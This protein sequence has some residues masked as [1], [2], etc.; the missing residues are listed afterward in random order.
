MESLSV[1]HYLA[2][3]GA[4]LGLSLVLTPLVRSL[5]RATGQVA[6]PRDTRWHKQ[7]TALL[8]GVAI[9]AATVGVWTAVVLA[10]GWESAGK[11]FLPLILCATGVFLLGLVDDI[12][13]LVPQHKL[14]A[15]IVIVSIFMTFGLRL[16][17]TVSKTAN[18]FLSILWVVGITNAFNLLDNMDGLAAGVA[19]IAGTFLFLTH[20]MNPGGA[21]LSVPFLVLCSVY[22]G[23]LL[24]FLVYNFNPASIFMGDAGSLFLGFVMASLTMVGEGDSVGYSAGKL[25]SVIAIPILILFI[26]ILDTGFVS[27]MRKLFRRPISQG[28][29]DHSSHRLVAIGFS[30][31]KAVLVLYGFAVASGLIAL[32]I[33]ALS[34]GTTLVLILFYLL[35]VGFFWIYLARVKVY[36]GRSVLSEEGTGTVT[37][38]LIQFTYRRRLFE[39]VL[40]LILITAAYYTAYLL[41]FEGPVYYLIGENFRFFLNSLPIVV[42]CQIFCFYVLGIYRGIWEATG[43]S[44]LIDYIKAITLGTV[45]A[46]LILLFVYRF[47]S[48]SRAVFVIHW[49]LLL[50]LISLSR[51]SFRLVDE[52]VKK[53]KQKGKRVLIYGAGAGGRMAA[54]EIENNPSLGL[55]IV[56]FL[57]DN[58]QKFKK[59]IMGYPVLGGRE[60]LEK[61]VR[62]RDVQGILVAFKAR[63]EEVR[64]ELQALF[65]KRDLEVEVRQM[66]MVLE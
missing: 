22:L 17:W 7:E 35:F 58:P 32:A 16:D 31:R 48:F 53:G 38:I 52:G 14:A 15:Q 2:F 62:K 57:D 21:A 34:I 27:F 51:L 8:G 55:V 10:L 40:D 64:R 24:G 6:V 20:Y 47:E 3:F 4:S 56:G 29:R 43:L 13:S 26:P 39:V 50:L 59:K 65:Q 9:F 61:V 12:V 28:G 60:E 49:I 23:A 1:T 30:E 11:P 41:R 54:K 66:K 19:L 46:M 25:L 5:A 33:N 37:P 18:L 42:A 45:T 36:E 63:G 44:D